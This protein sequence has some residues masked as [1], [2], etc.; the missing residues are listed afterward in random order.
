MFTQQ[1][2]S[3]PLAPCHTSCYFCYFQYLL[4]F[5]LICQKN[6]LTSH[7]SWSYSR[8]NEAQKTTT[9]TQVSQVSAGIPNEEPEDFVEAEFHWLHGLAD[10]N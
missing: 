1:Q 7:L 3:A 6:F 8:L 10:D 4:F 2:G 9:I 5:S